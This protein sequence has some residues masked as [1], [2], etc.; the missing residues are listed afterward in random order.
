MRKAAPRRQ[1]SGGQLT[2]RRWRVLRA[3]VLKEEPLCQLRLD[4]CTVLSNTVDHI[5]PMKFRPD[6]RYVRA[7][8]RGACQPC[9]QHRG[10][11]SLSVV[12][13]ED[14]ARAGARAKPSVALDFFAVD[15]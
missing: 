8:L 9:N 10:S 11:R 2:S 5:V 12:R 7:N 14:E 15:S 3:Q 13:A 1:P 6:L 4:C